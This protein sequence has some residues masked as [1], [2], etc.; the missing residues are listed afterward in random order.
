MRDDLEGGCN[1]SNTLSHT[2]PFLFLT[3]VILIASR[4]LPVPS[5]LLYSYITKHVSL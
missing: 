5:P 3:I 4:L 1:G 2:H